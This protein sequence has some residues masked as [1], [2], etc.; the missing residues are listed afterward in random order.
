M[1]VWIAYCTT[2]TFALE[3]EYSY[4]SVDALCRAHIVNKND[5]K[6]FKYD[7]ISINFFMLLN[8]KIT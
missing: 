6:L 5:G 2:F 7:L 1:K 4:R 8:P 3:D